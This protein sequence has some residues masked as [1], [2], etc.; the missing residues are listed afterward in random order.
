MTLLLTV[1]VGTEQGVLAAASWSPDAPKAGAA[2]TPDQKW[3]SADGRGHSAL[4]GATDAA[5]AG[6]RPGHTKAPGELPPE[7]PAPP[8]GGTGPATPPKPTQGTPVTIPVAAA[9]GY[10]ASTSQEQVAERDERSRTYRNTDGTFTTRFYTEPVNFRSGD[11]WKAIDTTLVRPQ[12][13]RTMSAS[14]EGWVPRQTEEPILLAEYA[15]ADPL[16]RLSVE[17]TMSVAYSLEGANRARGVTD[18][19]VITYPEVRPAADLELIAGSQSVKETIVLKNRTA[20]TQWRF[21]L[22]LQGLTAQLDGLGGVVFTDAAGVR[23]AWIPPGWMEDSDH[24]DNSAQGS[25]SS[26]VTYSLTEEGGRQILV[27]SLDQ[28]WL[29]APERVFPV[30]VDPS[31]TRFGASSGTYVQHP[32]NQ[33]FSTDTVL[34]TGTYDGGA[35][36]AA[37]FL[38]FNGVETTLKNAWVL[39]TSLALYN[40]WSYSCTARPVT[41][42]AVTSNWAENTTTKYPGPATGPSLASKSFA[43][44]WRPEGASSWN[45]GPA[46]ES[47]PLG[48]AGRQLV[49]DWTHGRKKNY[50]LAVKASTTDSKAWKQFGS[51]DYPN[52]KPSLDITWTKYGATYTLGQFTQA[53]TGVTEGAMQVTVTNRGQQ[54]WPRNGAVKLG[55]NLFNAA[56]QPITDAAKLR[57]TTLPSDVAPGASVTLSAK[58]APLPAATYTL[59][60]TMADGATTFTAEGVPGPA[61]RFSS[62]NI[63]PQLTAAAPPSGMVAD[64]LTPLLWANGTDQDRYP[65]ALQYQFEV[66][67]VAGRDTRKNCRLGP[68]SASQRWT[69]PSGWLS[70]GKTYAWYAYAYDGA[71]TSARPGP[72]LIT[73][74]VPQPGITSHLGASDPG[75]E[76]GTRAGNYT[77]AATDAAIPTVGPDLAVTRTYNSLDPRTTGIFGAGW[78]TRWEVTLQE[79]SYPSSSVLITAADGSQTRYGLNSDGT[80]T[81]PPGSTSQLY[82]KM[83]GWV[84]REQSGLTYGFGHSQF[85][86]A[87]TDSAGRSQRLIREAEDGGR[88][89]KVLDVL[90]GRTISL[91][92]TGE[93]VTSVTTSPVDAPDSK[94]TWTYTYTGDRLTKV[95]PPTSDT[96]CTNYTYEDGSLYRASVLDSNPRSYWR[97]GEEEGSTARSE[98]ASATGLNEATYRDVGFG[99]T[100]AV[101][102]TTDKAATFDGTDSHLELPDGTL[103]P[104][105]SVEVWFKTTQ[106][107]VIASLQEAEATEQPSRYS[108]FLNVDAAG[109]LRG[110]FFTSEYAGNQPIISPQ[111]VNDGQWH[112]AVLTSEGT[113]QTLYLDGEIVGSLTGTVQVREN[114]YAF[115]G[116]GWGNQGW[117]GVPAG[118]HPFKGNLDDVAVYSHPLDFERVREHYAARTAVGRMTQVTLPSGRTHSTAVYDSGTGRLTSSTDEDGGV[119]KISDEQYANGSAAYQDAVMRQAPAGYWRLGERTGSQAVSIAGTGMDGS[120]GRNVGL[121]APGVFADGDN[122]AA[123]FDGT[124]AVVSVPTDPLETADATSL[125][126]WFRTATPG[127]VLFGFQ[128]TEAGSTA[129][130]TVPALLIDGAGKLRGQLDRNRAGTSI[131]TPSAVTDNEW[132]HVVL[133]GGSTGQTMYLDG[134]RVGTLTGAVPPITLPHGY[135]GGGY[136][137]TAWNG[138]AAGTQYFRGQIDEAAF[139]TTALTPAAVTD[140]HRARTALVTGDGPHYRGVVVGDGPAGFW[141]MDEPEGATTAINEM[142]A[143]DADGTHTNVTLGTRGVFGLQDGSAAQLSGTGQTEVPSDLI[144]A[145][146]DVTVELWFRTTTRGV[147]LGLQNAAIGSTPT[148]YRPVLNVGAD[149]KLR[150]QFWTASQPNGAT[151]LTSADTVTD[152]QWHHAVLTASGTTQSLYLDGIKVGSLARA[153]QHTTGVRAYLGGGYANTAWMGVTTPGTYRFTGQLDEF[154]V[155]QRGL[156]QDEVENHY[157]ARTR[158]TASGLTSAVTVTD[159]AGHRTTAVYDALRAKRLLATTDAEGGVTSYAYDTG[160][161]LTT[162]TDPNGHTTVT[163]HN[164]R[165]NTISQTTCR[166]TNSC[167]T[168]YIDYYNNPAD[169]FD[170]RNDRPTATRDARSSGPADNRYRTA[171]AYNLLGLPT[172]T[173]LPDGRS[174]SIS[175]TDGTEPADGGGTTPAGLR[176]TETTTGGAITAYAYRANGDLARVTT[177]SGLVTEFTYDGLGRKTTEKQISDTFPAGVTTAY[178]YNA[179]SQ[180]TSETGAAVRNEIT[181]TTHTTRVTRTYNDDGA[182]LTETASDTTGGD[183]PRTTTYT[184]DPFGRQNKITDAEGN[185]TTLVHDSLGRVVH[186]TDTLGTTYSHTYT[187]QGFPAETTLKDWKGAPDGTVRDLVVAS[188]AYD[189]AGRLASST[190]AMGATTAYTYFNDGLPATTTARQVT[191]SDGTRRDIVL[192]SNTYDGAG[193]LT[194]E[195]TGGGATVVTQTVDATGRITKNT[196]DPTGL[197][198]IT[199]FAYDADD[200]ITEETRNIDTNRTLTATLAYDT[201]GNPVRETIGDGTGTPRTTTATYDRRGLPLTTVSPRGNT[202]GADPANHTTTFRYDALGRLVETQAPSAPVEQNGGT[203]T[204]TRPATLTG[205]NAHGDATAVRDARGNTTRTE[206]DRLSRPIAVTLP[207]YTPAGAVTPITSTTRTSYD[208]A[209]RP[210]TVTDPL[211]RIT[212][213]AYDQIG[214]L[215]QVTD[216]AVTDPVTTLNEQR[217]ASPL[218]N[219]VDGA[220]VTRYT[221]TPTGLALSATDPVGVRTEAT[222]DELGRELTSTTVERRPTLQN[223]TT[224]SVW[225]D[226]GDLTGTTT[227]EGRTSTALYNTAGEIISATDPLGATSRISYDGLGRPIESTDP[228]NRR[229]ITEYDALDNVVK[230]TDYGTGT[231][232]LRSTTA[233]FDADGNQTA[234]TSATGARTNYTYDALGRVTGQTETVSATKSISMSFGYDAEGNRTR[235]T[236]GRGN[237]TVYT[238]TPWNLPES[239]VEPSTAAHPAAADRTWSTVYD[240]AAQNIAE[241]LP[242]GV[243]RERTYDALG[244]V[245]AETGTGSEAPTAA[246]TFSYDAAGRLTAAGGAGALERNTFTYNDRGQLLTSTGPAGNTTYSYDPDGTMAS[247]RT[248][249]GLA[250]YGYDGAGHPWWT[251]DP[252]TKSQIWYDVDPAGRP[253]AEWYAVRADNTTPWNSTAVRKFTYDS[254]GRLTG[255]RTTDI[256]G[257]TETASTTYGYDLDD[258]VTAK[259]TTGTTGASANTYGYDDAGRMTSWTN[260]TTTTPY[261]WD[262]SSNRIQA[263]T[264]TTTYDERNRPLTD[265]TTTYTHTPRGTLSTATPAGNTPR[266]LT[267]DAFERKTS[268]GTTTFTYDSLD[269]VAQQGANA[270]TYDG[271]SNNLTSDGTNTYT[272]TLSGALQAMTDGTTPQWAITD[273]HTDLVA[274]FSPDGLTVTSSSAYDPFGRTTA[275]TGPR[276]SLGYQSGWTD[277][278]SGDVNM[279][280]RWYQPGTGAFASRDTWLLDPNPSAQANRY[281]YGNAGPLNGIDPDGHK[282]KHPGSGCSTCGGG[283]SATVSANSGHYGMLTRIKNAIKGKPKK[284]PKSSKGGSGHS[285]TSNAQARKNSVEI[286]RL[287][288]VSKRAPAKPRATTSSRGGGGH[289][290]KTTRSPHRGTAQTSTQSSG[291]RSYSSGGGTATLVRPTV[292]KPPAPRVPQNPNAGPRPTPAPTQPPPT[293]TAQAPSIW[294]PKEGVH[295]TAST[296]DLIKLVAHVVFH[297][298]T[299]SGSD[300][301]QQGDTQQNG[302]SDCRV[303]G[304]SWVDYGELDFRNGARATWMDSCLDSDYLARNKG[305]SP[306]RRPPG[307]VWAISNAAHHYGGGGFNPRYW[308]NSCHLLAAQLG[309]SG[310]ELRNLTA[311]ARSANQHRQDKLDPGNDK[312]MYE[313]EEK[314][315]IAVDGGQVVRYSVV[316]I[317]SGPRVVPTGW[318]MTAVGYSATGGRGINE[319]DFIPNEMYSNRL[320]R[321]VNIGTV[322]DPRTGVP[323]PVG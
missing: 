47:I 206:V 282:L 44:G 98:A 34:K 208:A 174:S 109:K 242:G 316:P 246:R 36:K 163:G 275:A 63:P 9:K 209:G 290:W 152:D 253:T 265:G 249:A 172:T 267:F 149:G 278:G 148:D 248:A 38:R 99:A 190:D 225:N 46:W 310:R 295:V 96:A 135:L 145:S 57:W 323:I 113:R 127:G 264:S 134:T 6:G 108:P 211:G 64:S 16:V 19:S 307:Y 58:V 150:G 55:Y 124:G 68:R 160:G 256:A 173:T 164:E 180:V 26:G 53:V 93:R 123:D 224:R 121:G 23:K 228:T 192:E 243:K 221:W 162:V 52:G 42:H 73:P 169:P 170:P 222:Y 181:D 82:R 182:I 136:T 257:T 230:A 144:T 289:A 239:T 298:Q 2:D 200:R 210:V 217:F 207:P 317:Y 187:P 301:G 223:L 314:V 87:I 161:F 233:E 17:D 126:L 235:M 112:H 128:N 309:G 247:R 74:E 153:A 107:G 101:A 218:T 11:G 94:L 22:T 65:S 115:L 299:A 27:V 216:P 114:Q 311:C 197:N 306:D 147:L 321:H 302:A 37:A 313:F 151:P 234:V 291:S 284:K 308:V 15:D 90:S 300:G 10:S 274:G 159:P 158:S 138:T 79:Q 20:Q 204:T 4:P 312:N 7:P 69:V 141:R 292:T 241:H 231:T 78:S 24:A 188:Y 61:V 118:V 3:G 297:A 67:E 85:L 199:T 266:A 229:S 183:T 238:Y 294:V 75:S 5:V 213:Y 318:Q 102:A 186:E 8:P 72:S 303:G 254:L 142:A 185:T 244:R 214:H 315:R 252:V 146:T 176:K 45:C 30:R 279:A 157:E 13:A 177:P 203:P 165:G 137:T 273:R 215:I 276:T 281:T 167:W 179:L 168:S 262:D 285:V 226:A 195:V 28:D 191:Q 92:W 12:G 71:A 48:S 133:T 171:F 105:M 236:D 76:F 130:S 120:Y 232:A 320:G 277:P 219:S 154:A 268:D 260:G 201:A 117:M 95:C 155:Y 129:T 288:R 77:T 220:G 131:V 269:R 25:V 132:H 40:T 97:L 263:G 59:Q 83:D 156:T 116:M 103:S 280:S 237:A 259:T 194:R 304:A 35:H 70:W 286:G 296:W 270:F 62:V 205:Y 100:P 143:H 119:W 189:P 86:G 18:G 271:G 125:E 212:R 66:C 122:S 139:Y 193:H 196:L 54:T 240:A 184:Y 251:D 50:G 272:R 33:N 178:T 245:T 322:Y 1:L 49:D 29:Q 88:I 227:P 166:D 305:T 283:S 51:D 287:D 104:V 140:H 293:P 258:R 41:V 80:Y 255:D 198:R 14:D 319:D 111:A 31:V 110:Q 89:M 84:L 32:Y 81:G 202:T 21:P 91:G 60:W 175:Y 106:P 56:G 43:H 39:G 261:G 250:T